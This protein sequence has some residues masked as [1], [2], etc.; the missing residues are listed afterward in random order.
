VFSGSDRPLDRQLVVAAGYEH[1]ALPVESLALLRRHPFRFAWR[2]W[3][4]F[5]EARSLL[6]V[7]KPAAV[8]GLGGFVCV[9]AAHAAIRKGIPLLIL[10]QNAI[11]GRATRFFSRRA[12]V[13][14]I[15]FAATRDKLPAG[16]RIELTGNPVRDPIADLY[17]PADAPHERSRPTVLVLGGSQGAASLNEIVCDLFV[18]QATQWNGWRI[19]HQTG[20]AQEPKVQQAYRTAGLAHH[21]QPFFENLA[22][23][24]SAAT[25]VISRS[26]ATT[27][28]ELACGGCPAVLVPYPYAID[29]HQ[30]VNARIFE[31]AGAAIVV[32]QESSA[33]ST[34]ERLTAAV[35]RLANNP[36]QQASMRQAM[37]SLARPD[38]AR[39][40]CQVLQ[41][42]PGGAIKGA[43]GIRLGHATLTCPH[44][45]G[46]TPATAESCQSCGKELR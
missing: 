37:L 7:E 16:S 44:C 2:T 24:Y 8:I 36:A 12:S 39:C 11:P 18:N 19:V 34:A 9:P 23:W 26:G 43:G 31:E 22:D 29:D 5:R 45:G 30:F 6:D 10:E 14:C 40:V 42:V 33:T 32:R 13:V 17:R 15:S 38:A 28:A 25:L 27:L 20:A 4:A 3:R 1:R 35:A 41:S 46:E 21:V